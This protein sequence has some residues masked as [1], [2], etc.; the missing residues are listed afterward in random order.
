[1]NAFIYAG[2]ECDHSHIDEQPGKDDLILAADSGWRHAEALGVQPHLVLGDFDSLG[3]IRLPDG[4]EKLVVPPEKDL[5]DTQLAV[6]EARSR[7]A[8]HITIIGGLGGRL[9]HSL[10]CLS[11]LEELWNKGDRLALIDNGKARV[12]FL[13]SDSALIPRSHYRYLSLIAV[14]PVLHGV[15]I[16]GVKYPLKRARLER[17]HQYAVSNEITGN[18]AFVAVRR[19]S[20]FIVE[21][22]D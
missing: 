22:C 12:R 10:S 17:N 2:G 20:L 9:D 1:M 4:V 5:T 15:E 19:G 8:Q 6:K 11:I 13:S 14:D 7:G 18:C 3:D 16:D 21:S